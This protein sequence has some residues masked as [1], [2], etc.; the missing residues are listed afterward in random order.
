M[1]TILLELVIAA[2]VVGLIIWLI[3]QIPGVQPFANII[4]VIAIC[5]FVIYCIYILM[6]LIGGIP[7]HLR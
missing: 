2:I 7:P 5:I 6:G 4:R 3:S 1:I